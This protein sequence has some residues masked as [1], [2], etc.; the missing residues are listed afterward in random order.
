[1]MAIQH[2]DYPYVFP[3]QDRHG[4]TRWRYRRAGVDKSLPGEPHTPGFDAAYRAIIHG[5]PSRAEVIP[6]SGGIRPKTL[7]HAYMLL[8]QS[9]DWLKLDSKSRH[10][11]GREIEKLLLLTEEGGKAAVAD[12]PLDEFERNNVEQLLSLYDATPHMQRIVLICIQKLVM[13]G[14]KE[15]W[16]KWD[17]TYKMLREYEPWTDGHAAWTAEQMEQYER[18]HKLGS[19]AR[20]A[21]ALALWLGLRVSDIVRL[22]WTQLV[23]KCVLFE[24]SERLV[25]GFE[26]EQFKGRKKRKLKKMFLPVSPVL[27]AELAP[28]SRDTEL[29]LISERTKRGYTAASL[30]NRFI[31]WADAAGL[32]TG[33]DAGDSALSGHGLRKSLGNLMAEAGLTGRQMQDIFG[34]SDESLIGLYSRSADQV[35][36]AVQGMDKIVAA[37]E[38]MK[39]LKVVK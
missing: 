30:S 20:V 19:S 22:R 16:I 34:H 9:K 6:L 35:R 37:T 10:R 5:A 36:L 33:K 39:R 21:Y 4:K 15:R 12:F 14:I 38:K 27:E 31:E 1:M 2:P 32:P 28:L 25:T 13:I 23:T 11:Y 18:R 17:P 26:F 24:D 7:K 29:V 8:K 3:Y